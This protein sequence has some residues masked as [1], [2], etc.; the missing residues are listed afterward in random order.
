[1][2]CDLSFSLPR[3]L[4]LAAICQLPGVDVVDHGAES[5]RIHAVDVDLLDLPQ[6]RVHYISE[7][8]SRRNIDD[9]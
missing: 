1:M 5:D 7:E 6:V 4:S 2:V 3:G 8:W 9:L